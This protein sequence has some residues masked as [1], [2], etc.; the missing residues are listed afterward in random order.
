M[1]SGAGSTGNLV[2][3]NFIGMNVTGTRALANYSGVVISGASGTTIG[4]TA[5]A[6]RN[7]ISG[8]FDYNVWI[9]NGATGT[10]VQ[11]NFLGTDSTG[12]VAPI[13]PN[14]FFPYGVFITDSSGNTVGG[15]TAAARNVISGNGSGVVID[16]N[17]TTGNLVQGNFIGTDVTGTQP[18]GNTND[19]VFI[20]AAG[21][22]VGGTAPG[23]RNLISGNGQNGVHAAGGFYSVAGSTVQGNFIGTDVTGTQPLGNDQGVLIDAASGLTIGGAQAGAGNV[24]AFNTATGVGVLSGDR[25]AILSS[26]IFANGGLGIDFGV[27]VGFAGSPTFSGRPVPNDPGDLDQGPNDLQNYPVLTSVTSAGGQ[28]T[29]QGTLNSTAKRTFLI[30]FFASDVADP[31]GFGPGQVLLGQTSVTTGADGNASIA[32]TFPVTPAPGQV[33]SATAT[34]PAGNTSEFSRNVPSTSADLEVSQSAS[35][36]FGM[37]PLTFTVTVANHGPDDAVRVFL[38]DTPPGVF[39]LS[40]TASQGTLTTGPRGTG[41]VYVELGTIPAGAQATLT[42]ATSQNLSGPSINTATVIAATADPDPDNN[43]SM[44]A[45]TITPAADLAVSQAATPDPAGAGQD[46]TY[47]VTVSNNGPSPASDV[48]VTDTLPSGAA[49]LSAVAGDSGAVTPVGPDLTVSLGALAAGAQRTIIITVR[50]TGPGLLVNTVSVASSTFEPKAADNSSTLSTMVTAPPAAT[51]GPRVVAL[52]PLVGRRKTQLVLTFSEQLDPTRAADRANYRLVALSGRRGGS[53]SNRAI[54]LASAAY[55]PA[56][57]TV[58]LT[59]RGRLP[60]GRRYQL[61]VVGTGPSGLTDGAGLALASVAGGPGADYIA[62]IA[63]RR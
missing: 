20:A 45:A 28:T 54:P 46:L 56:S 17:D 40:A 11:G 5:A 36:V 25:D 31:S 29:I 62:S 30:Q 8:N 4:G 21:D 33:V 2:Q 13:G 61:T 49:F 43:V 63:D 18:L 50:P 12:G 10:E 7:V 57:R 37:G 9:S 35:P 38:T 60:V 6:A 58:T 15:T 51:G 3:G 53:R 52:H 42:L 41:S 48:V 26:S 47:T 1:I 34:D 39:L 14:G 23:A 19:G 55:D 24:I 22:T 16:G 32:A 27:T 59:P 44:F